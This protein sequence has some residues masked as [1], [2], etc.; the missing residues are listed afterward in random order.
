MKVTI[1]REECISCGACYAS[2]PQVFEENEEDLYSQIV[3]EHRL[4]GDLAR[5][6]V[7]E[8]LKACVED[9]V[10]GCPVEIIHTDE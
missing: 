10:Y 6:E 7:L 8:D 1:D 5:G 9:A 3:K 2:C 4:G